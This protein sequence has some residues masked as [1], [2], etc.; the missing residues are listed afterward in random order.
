MRMMITMRTTIY[1][2]P[3]D[4]VLKPY[5]MR[6]VTAVMCHRGPALCAGWNQLS[7][8]GYGFGPCGCGQ[9]GVSSAHTAAQILPWL[10]VLRSLPPG[11]AYWKTAG[12]CILPLSWS[13]LPLRISAHPGGRRPSLRCLWAWGRFLYPAIGCQVCCASS[14]WLVSDVSVSPYPRFLVDKSRKTVDLLLFEV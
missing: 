14:L 1:V 2:L 10:L 8:E 12:S 9:V 7:G 11:V 4:R 13:L 5:S 3:A 6:L